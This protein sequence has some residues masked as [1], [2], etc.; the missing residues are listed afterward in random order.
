MAALKS[1]VCSTECRVWPEA[2]QALCVKQKKGQDSNILVADHV[3]TIKHS[4]ESE[5]VC[6]PM[7]VCRYVVCAY[8]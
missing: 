3:N 6:K 8:V 5:F 4:H 2:N 1:G 7:C